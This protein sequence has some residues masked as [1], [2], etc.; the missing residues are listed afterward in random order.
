[1]CTPARYNVGLAPP[2]DGGL[3]SLNCTEL[4]PDVRLEDRC[5]YLSFDY[6]VTTSIIC[7]LSLVFGILYTLFGECLLLCACLVRTSICWQAI[8]LC[9]SVKQLFQIRQVCSC[10]EM[11]GHETF[12][13][14]SHPAPPPRKYE[15]WPYVILFFSLQNL[16]IVNHFEYGYTYKLHVQ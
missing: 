11:S 15:L 7:G 10:R 5:R 8:P 3:G 4:P 16:N 14:K 9:S 6:D 2:S 12:N 1:M 13:G